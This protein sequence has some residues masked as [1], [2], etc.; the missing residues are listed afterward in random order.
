MASIYDKSSLVLIPSG[1]KT[2]KVYSQVPVSGDGDFTFT[3]SSAAT[4][5][6]A[7]GFIEKETQN[8]LLQSNNFD[9]TWQIGG[10]GTIT[11][12]QAGYDG[13]NNASLLTKTAAWT[14]VNQNVNQSGVQTF[15]VYVKANASTW[16]LLVADHP[17]TDPIA[18]FDLTNGVVGS[19]TH[20]LDPNIVDVGNDWWRISITYN[21]AISQ[22]RVYPAEANTAS[23]SSGSIYIQDAQ[24]EQGLVARDYIET[25]TTA[26]EGGI[27]DNVPRLDYTDSSCPALLLEPQRTNLVMQSELFNVDTSWLASGRPA[28]ETNI[29]DSP[30]GIQNASRLTYGAGNVL[31]YQQELTFTNGYS[32]S[33]FVKKDVGRYVTIYAAFFTTT[34]TIG[35]D[36]DEGTCQAGGVIEPYGDGWYRISVSKSVAGDADKSGYFY[37]YSTN[38]LGSTISTN[39]NKIYV[40]G[41]QIEEGSYATSYIPTYGSSVTRVG[42]LCVKTG[43]S[44]LIGQTEG[45]VYFEWDYQN[46]G[47]SGGNI[48]MSLAGASLQELYF[49]VKADGTYVYD[50]YDSTKQA[51]IS[52]SMGSFGT[53]KIALAY[54]NN[55]FVLYINGVLAGSDTSGSV[56]T[57]TDVYIGRYALNTNYNIASGVKQA[58]LFKTRL[59]NEELAA[60]TTI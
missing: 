42:E 45:V 14:N 7:D 34:A 32:Y 10:A 18:Y 20:M 5:V 22:V 58:L 9:T 35:F 25:T 21:M 12:N 8:L 2:G 49:W 15:S 52:G 11:E 41:A 4:R 19:T 3:R 37:L 30:E 54:K 43:I 48:I 46:T 29:I 24:L 47:S 56:P 53:K 39:G 44:N 26:V 23:G 1:T 59:S 40:Y 50:V 31:R 27:T 60:L 13:T 57:L 33:I 6:N 51:G 17:S 36:L 28:V 55:D 16:A 38:A